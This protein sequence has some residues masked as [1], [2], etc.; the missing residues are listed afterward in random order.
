MTYSNHKYTYLSFLVLATLISILSSNNPFFWD[1]LIQLSIPANWYYNTNFSTFYI[2]S[3][4]GTGHPTFISM[5]LASVWKLFGRSLFVSHLAFLPIIYGFILETYKLIFFFSKHRVHSIL[6]LIL[7]LIETTILSQLSSLTFEV[8]HLYFLVL[9]LNAI[10]LNKRIL[11]AIAFTCLCLT[12][13]RG[14]ISAF[15]L[16]L[17]ALIYYYDDVKKIKLVR[18]KPFIPG[19]IALTLFL[20]SFYLVQNWVIHNTISNKWS[21][22]SEMASFNQI[23]SNFLHFSFK[24]IDYGKIILWVF[25]A[26]II[27]DFIY[28]KT[29]LSHETKL[30]LLISICQIVVFAI[31][32]LPSR[33]SIGHR[34]LI[35]AYLFIIILIG[36]WLFNQKHKLRIYTSI[37]VLFIAG[38]F[39]VYPMK[40][41]QG[42]DSSTLQWTYFSL[43]REA[44]NYIEE[45]GIDICEVGTYFPNSST[46]EITDLNP[47]ETNFKNADLKNDTYIL[48]S[49][50]YNRN[51]SDIDELFSD[52]WNIIK[53]F[54][55]LNVNVILFK[56]TFSNK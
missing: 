43:R 12:S 41:S 40:M 22:S 6:I 13:L 35:P 51:D 2:P 53:S 19:L 3:E 18:F 54:K 38:N 47:Q 56:K 48:F 44:I 29:K 20:I 9:S 50:V 26:K 30:L 5:Y 14:S 21:Q 17:F 4:I 23:G 37:L 49:N 8:F 15:G 27:F 10:L 25:I 32:I 36:L 16:L 24:F 42:W 39:V 28:K 33:N 31:V 55:R 52:S 45:N 11:L 1:N 46:F 7:V 34:Y